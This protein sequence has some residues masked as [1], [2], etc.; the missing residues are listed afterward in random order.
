[1][2]EIEMQTRS[3]TPQQIDSYEFSKT[4]IS[5]KSSEKLI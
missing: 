3:N 4:G 1:M 2:A 5:D